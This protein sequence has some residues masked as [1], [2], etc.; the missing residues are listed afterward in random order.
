MLDEKYLTKKFLHY[1]NFV[2]KMVYAKTHWKNKVKSDSTWKGTFESV[3]VK[4][5]RS[6]VALVFPLYV[7]CFL[8]IR[9]VLGGPFG[10]YWTFFA[11]FEAFILKHLFKYQLYEK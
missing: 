9:I 1:H 11:L 5:N 2:Q 8:C 10:K 3:W 4:I 6:W 7:C